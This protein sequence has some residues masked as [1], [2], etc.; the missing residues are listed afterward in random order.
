MGEPLAR[1]GGGCSACGQAGDRRAGHAG[2]PGR[3]AGQ[4][5]RAVG[6]VRGAHDAGPAAPGEGGAAGISINP[7][8]NLNLSFILNLALRGGTRRMQAFSA[9][10]DLIC[11]VHGLPACS[12]CVFRC[13]CARMRWACCSWRKLGCSC[14]PSSACSLLLCAPRQ[15]GHGAGGGRNLNLYLVDPSF[16]PWTRALNPD[17][18]VAGQGVVLVEGGATA[19]FCAA[20]AAQ[21]RWAFKLDSTPLQAPRS[22]PELA[23]P[24]VPS[25]SHETLN[26]A[27]M[28]LARARA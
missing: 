3:I 10:Q 11:Y 17:A 9:G 12:A 18:C 6:G 8:P 14:A 15:A 1:A 5:L 24:P 4:R 22:D 7:K 13:V 28:A 25:A 26:P 21:H 2:R 27:T 20:W 19:G 16:E 23:L